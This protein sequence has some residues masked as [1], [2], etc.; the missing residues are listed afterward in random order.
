MELPHSNKIVNPPIGGTGTQENTLALW[1]ASP[2][3]AF[4]RFQQIVNLFDQLV[5]FRRVLLNGGLFA[6]H[7]P[8]LFVF[9]NHFSHP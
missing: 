9:A 3:A 4:L 1:G 7:F 5:Q 8:F 6:Q 2:Q